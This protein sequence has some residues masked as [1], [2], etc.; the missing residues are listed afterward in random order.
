M[1]AAILRLMDDASSEAKQAIVQRK[2]QLPKPL[3]SLQHYGLAVL[4]V[5]LALGA[6]LLIERFHM[7][8]V[9]VP[10]FLFAVAV[11]AWYGGAGPALLSLLLAFLT[12]DYFFVEPIHN[13]YISGADL[14][15][16]IV[17]AT[18][19]TLV[20]WFSALRRRVEADLRQ[21][22]RP[23]TD[24]GGGTNPAGQPAQSDT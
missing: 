18:F 13:L 7:R 15:Y 24:R 12:F 4:S 3:S 21:A 14:P 5:S 8:D 6:A 22:P 19:A 2:R 10:L 23:S 1:V 16:F 9:E 20:T 11:S 17:F